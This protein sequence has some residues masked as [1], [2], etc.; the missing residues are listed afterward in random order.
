MKY[1]KLLPFVLVFALVLGCSS[2]DSASS[3]S[4]PKAPEAPKASDAK[5]KEQVQP[6]KPTGVASLAKT[7]ISQLSVKDRIKFEEY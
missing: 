2:D 3:S 1:F 5:T 6:V 4:A 7:P